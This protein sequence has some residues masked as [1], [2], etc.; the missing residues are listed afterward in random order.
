MS[1]QQKIYNPVSKDAGITF[2]TDSINFGYLNSDDSASFKFR[3]SSTGKEPLI[4]RNVH[5]SCG[6]TTPEWPQE[7][8][9]PGD[10][11]IVEVTFHSKGKSGL[12]HQV[13]NVYT[14]TPESPVV[15]HI[16][17]FVKPNRENIPHNE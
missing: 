17:G 3:F 6:C 4:I 12:Q 11:G 15:L 1:A 16:T 8:I 10:S 2:K 13:V 9:M 7:K 14:N 5:A